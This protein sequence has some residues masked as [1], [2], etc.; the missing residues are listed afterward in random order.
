MTNNKEVKERLSLTRKNGS[1]SNYHEQHAANIPDY[2]GNSKE[3]KL[4]NYLEENE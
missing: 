2:G 1:G 3:E 4:L